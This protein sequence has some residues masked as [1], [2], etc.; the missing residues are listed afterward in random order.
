M[1]TMKL[2][3]LNNHIQQQWNKKYVKKQHVCKKGY[4]W[5]S[6]NNLELLVIIVLL[7]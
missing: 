2:I 3:T 4:F 5:N 7:H 6:K 1:I